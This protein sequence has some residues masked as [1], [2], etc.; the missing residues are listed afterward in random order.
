M[1]DPALLRMPQH[2]L[3]LILA[4]LDSTQSLASAILS[5]SYIYAT[6]QDDRNRILRAVR[7][8]QMPART[9]PY[10]YLTLAAGQMQPRDRAQV[11]R[12]LWSSS[13]CLDPHSDLGAGFLGRVMKVDSVD[14]RAVVEGLNSMHAMVEWFTRDFARDTLPLVGSELGLK[15]P[16]GMTLSADETFRI[17]RA[18]YRFQMYCDML[19]SPMDGKG[20][21]LGKRLRRNFFGRFS[22]WVNE[23]LACVHDYFERVLSRAFD[24]V[25]AHDVDWG[26]QRINWLANGERNPHKQ[27]Y[28][29]RGIPFLH[30]L[31]HA[32]TY[33]AR[34]ALLGP[35]PPPPACH[36]LGTTLW[37]HGSTNGRRELLEWQ[38]FWTRMDDPADPEPYE[39]E[40]EEGKGKEGPRWWVDTL[41]QD[42]DEGRDGYGTLPFRY[43]RAAHRDCWQKDVVAGVNARWLRRVGYVMW[44]EQPEGGKVGELTLRVRVLE[45]R[46][47]VMLERFRERDAGVRRRVRE[48]RRARE[49][50]YLRGGRGYWK[51]GDMGEVVWGSGDDYR[52]G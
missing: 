23:Q 7:V 41:W 21:W 19:Q 15:R 5:H 40:G 49:E 38:H 26:H 13:W 27:A 29:F 52:A 33:A 18:M 32:P 11:R 44:D 1:S 48:G 14:P 17:Q 4:Q 31:A 42:D 16:G 43:W 35:I 37:K 25:A 46:K 47:A 45:G 39:G 34:R 3:A 30:T 28:L 6:F 9:R 51:E 20:N 50:I 22:P 24:E 10:A 36:M 8:D 12:F 2:L